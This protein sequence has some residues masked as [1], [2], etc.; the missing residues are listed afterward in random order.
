VSATPEHDEFD[1]YRVWLGIPK[2]EQPPHHYRLLGVTLFETDPQ[3]IQEGADRQ[4]AHLKTKQTGKHVALSQQLLQQVTAAAGC[5]LDTAAKGRYDEQLRQRLAA[6]T[7]PQQ[8]SLNQP[9]GLPSGYPPPMPGQQMLPGHQQPVGYAQAYPPHQTPPQPMAG[10]HYA[11]PQY[12]QH[13]G[14][15]PAP[16]GAGPAPRPIPVHQPVAAV[17]VEEPPTPTSTA[18]LLTGVH[19]GSSGSG[20]GRRHAKSF[21]FEM[22]K[23]VAGGLLGI[24]IAIGGFAMAGRMD[25][26]YG[27]VGMSPAQP[28]DNQVAKVDPEK[29][30]GHSATSSLPQGSGSNIANP[31][32][33][34]AG[35]SGAGAS[36]NANPPSNAGSASTGQTTTGPT[37]SGTA[38]GTSPP[39]TPPSTNLAPAGGN[40]TASPVTNSPVTISPARLPAAVPHRLAGPPPTL[41]AA[42]THQDATAAFREGVTYAAQLYNHL[43]TSLQSPTYRQLFETDQ[44][45]L[46]RL[47][48][49]E[50]S[51]GTIPTEESQLSRYRSNL[52]STFF[53]NV[54]R[55]AVSNG[56]KP[57]LSGRLIAATIIP[58]RTSSTGPVGRIHE[59]ATDDFGDHLSQ[60]IQTLCGLAEARQQEPEV[61][62]H[63]CY[64]AAMCR[65]LQ[66]SYMRGNADQFATCQLI[67]GMCN[68]VGNLLSPDRPLD[69]EL[70]QNLRASRESLF[71]SLGLGD[72]ALG[73]D[74]A[75][76]PRKVFRT[77]QSVFTWQADGSW[78]ENHNARGE[79]VYTERKRTPLQIELHPHVLGQ[80]PVH[81]ALSWCSEVTVSPNN[82]NVQN[83]AYQSG[84]WEIP[85]SNRSLTPKLAIQFPKHPDLVA[86][87]GTNPGSNPGMAP[88]TP[89]GTGL[90]N[91]LASVPVNTSGLPAA[92]I[93]GGKKLWRYPN[94]FIE[95]TADGTWR[96]FSPTGDYLPLQ[97]VTQAGDMVEFRRSVGDQQIRVYDNRLEYARFGYGQFTE[98]AKGSWIKPLENIALDPPQQAGLKRTVDQFQ[99]AS[100][101]AR[102]N[103]LDAF[104]KAMSSNRKR[105]GKND[106]RLA[107]LEILRVEKDR[108]EKEGL[109]PWSSLMKQETSDYLATMAKARMTADQTLSKAVD[110]YLNQNQLETAQ[111]LMVVKQKLLA[112]VVVA[113]FLRRDGVRFGSTGSSRSA[114]GAPLEVQEQI[115][116][117]QMVEVVCNGTFRFWSNGTLND[118]SGA[119]KWLPD[120]GGIWLNMVRSGYAP[121]RERIVLSDNGKD[122]VGKGGYGS[123][124]SGN[125]MDLLGDT[126]RRPEFVL[127]VKSA[128]KPAVDPSPAGTTSAE[129]KPAP[130]AKPADGEDDGDLRFPAKKRE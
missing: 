38:G 100:S 83:F 22:V 35:T 110:Y 57:F 105:I 62:D 60:F 23:I 2:A 116:R 66:F 11:Q 120:A 8:A 29:T 117:E 91:P 78:V 46:Q 103:M 24:A 42:A 99:D 125:I 127:E 74:P 20:H 45:T 85:K 16:P 84:A 18:P 108:F 80:T 87:S 1:A 86:M 88:G 6:Q 32:T 30:E 82:P 50:L 122:F 37:I 129:P 112:P 47:A 124:F 39:G 58:T 121:T 12:Q 67:D 65:G 89:P 106:E 109:V 79:S 49:G 96:E 7:A 31:E 119:S 69:A 21:P 63:L 94:G 44:A 17:S 4:I 92:P 54:D 28:S 33:S 10:G 55:T 102:K 81:L 64:L 59:S 73:N 56:G 34:A 128:A 70:K 26:I 27:L 36:A 95:L 71:R 126:E 90:T 53:D 72:S 118:A 114:A 101:R 111:A 19:S 9:G 5:L 14:Y 41:P 75:R 51:T 15:H 3:V 48:S 130:A 40:S 115:M 98:V 93:A 113:R 107:Q 68:E 77:S 13:P 61:H 25:V 123:D 104:E 43:Q 97:L 76:D 52:F